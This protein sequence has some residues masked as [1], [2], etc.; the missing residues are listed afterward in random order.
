MGRRHKTIVVLLAVVAV[1]LSA[2]AAFSAE[3][4]VRDFL[5]DRFA[6]ER[7]LRACENDP[8]GL[9]RTRLCRNAR[10]ARLAATADR[11]RQDRRPAARR[12]PLPL[13]PAAPPPPPPRRLG[14]FDL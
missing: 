13:P 10:A 14:G 8:G 7:Q 6:L 3:G 5:D 2:R 1:I 4:T 12:R 11:L 9:G